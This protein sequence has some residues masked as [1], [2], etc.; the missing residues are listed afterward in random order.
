MMATTTM[1]VREARRASRGDGA[2]WRVIIGVVLAALALLTSACSTIRLGY[3]QAPTLM[4]HWLDS[5]V[6]F[7]DAQ[8]AKAREAFDDLLRWHR[9]TQLPDYAQWLSANAAR[10]DKDVSG[11]Q[12][13]GFARELEGRWVRVVD[14]LMPAA[15]DLA[16]SLSD[17]QLAR[18]QKRFGESLE[19]FREEYAARDERAREEADY[20]RSVSRSE[21]IYGSLDDAQ[22]AVLAKAAKTAYFDAD[23]VVAERKLR[24]SELLKMIRDARAATKDGARDDVVAKLQ[25]SLKTWAEQGMRSARPEYRAQQQR[26][27]ERNCELS[28]QV[29]NAGGADVRKAGRA[30]LEEW[31]ADARA[32]AEADPR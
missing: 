22:L 21:W 13:C 29:H 8:G 18:V 14:R 17:K 28:A 24:Q 25:V 27:Q 6:D 5:W 9:R 1:N 23:A 32:L 26:M 10:M 30:K 20:K 19:R 4:Y 12:M 11:E 31:A 15:A 7:D 3:G 2:G 16:V